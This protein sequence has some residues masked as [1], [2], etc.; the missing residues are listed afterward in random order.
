L[1]IISEPL[2]PRTRA[3]KKR[4]RIPTAS[5]SSADSSGGLTDDGEE[6]ETLDLTSPPRGKLRI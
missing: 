6:P 4:A 1:I 5:S 2:Q 3:G